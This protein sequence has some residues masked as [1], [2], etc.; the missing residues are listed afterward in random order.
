M[1][2]QTRSQD[3][4]SPP[5]APEAVRVDEALVRRLVARQFPQWAGLPLARFPSAGTVN[6]VYRLGE[7]LAVRLPLGPDGAADVRKEHRWL[8][9]LAP[10]LPVAVPEV[11]GRGEPGEGYPWPWTV[12]RWIE[13]A[14]PVQGDVPRAAE[15]ATE[16]AAF[17]TALRRAP[18]AGAPPAYR[19]RPLRAVDAATRAAIDALGDD[20]DAAAATAAWE[21]ALAAP[22]WQG[23]P[24]WLH[25]DLMPGNLLL[26][27]GRLAA[28]LDFGTM[29]VGDPAADLIPAWNLLPA[30]ARETFRAALAPGEAEWRRGHGWALSMALIQLPYYR[31]RNPVLAANARHTIAQTLAHPV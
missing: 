14:H 10:L 19:G 9:R 1:P 11:L 24:T 8:P 31:D 23:P 3:A 12:H 28:V 26:A 4:P 16:L 27:N 17:V 30:N 25:S 20:I 5:G 29:G 21:R 7:R 22:E 15:L 13:G 18:A 2:E 6:A